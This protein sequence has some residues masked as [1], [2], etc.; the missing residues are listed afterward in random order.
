[1]QNE[2]SQS[3]PKV[4]SESLLDSKALSK[5]LM[6]KRRELCLNLTNFRKKR[7]D[8]NQC[9]DRT[10]KEVSMYGDIFINEIKTDID[11]RKKEIQNQKELQLRMFA[12]HEEKVTQMIKEVDKTLIKS[13]AAP[14]RSTG[15]NGSDVVMSVPRCKLG[16]GTQLCDKEV[17]CIPRCCNIRF[18]PSD[19]QLHE[20]A[21]GKIII[22]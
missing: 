11:R 15:G 19:I 6:E 7:D 5:K 16:E 14:V 2:Q 12:E 18:V 8:W 13:A 4:S 20:L 10:L 3:K 21:I 1:M 22:D 17:P 9:V